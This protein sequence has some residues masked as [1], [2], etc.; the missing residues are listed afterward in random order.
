[1]ETLPKQFADALV[2]INDPRAPHAQAAHK[3]VRNVLHASEP[4]K[5]WGIETVLIGS[6][7]RNTSIYPGKDVDVFSKLTEL[8]TRASPKDVFDTFVDVLT[9]HYGDLAEP[10]SR[11]VKVVFEF[12]GDGGDKFHVD[13][14]PAVR[15]GA[16]WAI[17]NQD[18]KSWSDNA[19]WIETDPEDLTTKTHEK[20]KDPV[21]DGQGMYVPTAKLIKQIRSHHLDDLK[22][23]GLYFELMAYWAFD[24]G[25]GQTGSYAELLAE[26]LASAAQQLSVAVADPLL[27]PVLG[28]P[29]EPRPTNDELARAESIISG[30]ARRA[31]QALTEERCPAAAIWRAILGENGRGLCFPLPEG[32]DEHGKEVKPIVSVASRGPRERG[33]FGTG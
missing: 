3:D 8:D 24:R 32:C 23:G 14:V 4:L 10:Q 29:L 22:P 28:T 15:L 11:S 1:M 27:D 5:A 30:L 21:L 33:S 18:P 26:V 20:N 7:A 9:A 6:Y 16:R 12:K 31:A 17:P 13:V 19:S 25:L 2:R